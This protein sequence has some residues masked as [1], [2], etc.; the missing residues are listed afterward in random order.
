MKRFFS[1]MWRLISAPFRLILR[2]FQAVRDFI[3]YEPEDTSVSEAF[4]HVIDKPSALIE[5]IEELRVHLFRALI[6]LALTTLLSFTFAQRIFAFLTQPIGG[7]EALQAIE[8]TESLGAYMRVSLLSGIALGF[9]YIIFE[10]FAFI[11]PGL[12]KQERIVFLISI[13]AGTILFLGG[14]A[15]TYFVMLPVALPFLLNFLGI[16]TQP[17]P[18]NYISFVTSLMFWVGIA[19]QFPLIIYA[20]ASIGIVQA[21]SLL[22]GWRIAIVAIAIFAAMVTPTIDPVNMGLVM[23]PMILLYFASIGL[24]ALAGRG[25]D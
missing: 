16:T 22:K 19:F 13:P 23:A 15:F 17:R 18:S 24:A 9:P 1:A 3:N 6:V 4:V 20:L 5:H 12:K 25:E 8:V 2:P 10:I 7:I 14:L 11:N 21:K